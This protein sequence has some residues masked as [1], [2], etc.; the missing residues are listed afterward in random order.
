MNVIIIPLRLIEHEK[1]AIVNPKLDRPAMAAGSR[2]SEIMSIR[3]SVTEY[4]RRRA[5]IWRRRRTERYISSLPI[6]I[7][8]DIGWP[9]NGS[10][11]RGAGRTFHPDLEP[12]WQQ[13]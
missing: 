9:G 1:G 5:A 10:A 12:Q 8:K 4:L 2:R 6:E 13:R 7:R 3:A 11:G